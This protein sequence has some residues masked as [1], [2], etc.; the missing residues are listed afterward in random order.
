M[1][2]R[3]G[4][5]VAQLGGELHGDP[6]CVIEQVASLEAAGRQ[7]IAFM[8]GPKYRKAL[9]QSL[10]GVV[11]VSPVDG[12]GLVRFHIRVRNPSL[13]FARVAQLLNPE[14]IF[15]PGIQSGAMVAPDAVIDPSAH[16]AAGAVVGA[17]VRIG[18]ASVIGAGS[19]VGD[20]C[21]IGAA[22]RLHARVTLYA[23]CVVGDRCVLHSGSVIGADGF[24]FAREAD[25]SWVKIPQIGRVLIGNDVEVGAN[26]TID[27]GAL[28]DTV[29]GNGVKLDNLI[30]I[31]HNVHVG[32]H[33]AMAACTGVAGSTH[34]G[35]RCMI[36]GSVNIMGHSEIADDVIVS[37]V[38]FVSK[39]ITEAGV[40]TGSLPS[41]E[42]REWS[43]N[44]ARIR[45]LDSMADRLRSL[46]RL[47]A[48]QQ[49][50]KED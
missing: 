17:R 29:I 15:V 12:T 21:V 11:I 1:P 26:T 40:Y 20:D 13:Y 22:T 45:Q 7:H 30:Q 44:F 16:I 23:S 47:V 48:S 37:A 36:G 3:L 28:D 49:S 5:V 38:T 27:R 34:I 4:D 39:S 41:M 8:S 18:A 32:E 14:P 31:A 50:I 10:A 25:A 43:R 33:T 19:V 42:H 6:D 24:G 9:D 46:E 2:A 35:S